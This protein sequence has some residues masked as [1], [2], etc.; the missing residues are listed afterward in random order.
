MRAWQ[1]LNTRNAVWQVAG[2][3]L[4]LG[5]VGVTG[6]Y[7][8]RGP[9][10]VKPSNGNGLFAG[11]G[12]QG[13]FGTVTEPL[14]QGLFVLS[15]ETILGRQKDLQLQGV[16]GRL[17]ET[18]T[19]WK[20]LSPQARKLD[21]TWTL[22]GPMAMEA[23]APGTSTLL[24]KGAIAAQGPALGWQHGVWSG[25]SPL[26]WEDLQGSGRGRWD[27]PSGWH[28][29]LDGRFIVEK[30]PVHWT[31]ADPGALRSLEAQRMDA[32][33][34]F[35]EGHLEQVRAQLV[36]GDLESAVVDILPQWINWGGPIGFH[37]Q[38]GWHGQASQG[39]APRPAQGKPFD[40]M[41]LKDFK[42]LRSVEGGQ[43]VL[44][45]EG[46]RWTPAGL[47]LEGG[48]RWEQPADGLLLTLRAPRVLQRTGPGEDL[49]A[50]LP[51]GEAWA[52]SQAVLT[53]G[54]RSLSSPR[55]EGRQK[56]RR[57]RILAPALGRSEFGT[58][59]AGEGRGTPARWEFDG[60]I[61]ARFTDGAQV[62]GDGLLWEGLV[63]TLTG[64]PATLTRIRQRLS[65]P[66]LVRREDAIQF[67]KGIAGALAAQDGDITLRADQGQANRAQVLLEGRVECQGQG[68]RLQADRI[69]VTLGP[70]N[71]VKQVKANGTVVLRGR[72]GEGR[73]DS[74]DLDP[75]SQ[76]ADWAGRVKAVTEV[77]P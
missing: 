49:P 52:E 45:A 53:W 57:W 72:M 3:G 66:Q 28:R 15:Y 31:A 55:I 43:E 74:L 48:V 26:V 12:T 77:R 62:R 47:R 73:G 42:A 33:L 34:G 9:R 27:L 7:V 20:L 46:A 13:R 39:R 17:E 37:R 56:Q 67:P 44:T 50:A 29:G 70:G 16:S 24:G 51:L 63:W 4:I 1:L 36:D 19:T 40:R 2:L 41:E 32:G 22:M 76:K 65:G 58:F 59:T 10:P 30:G 69:S 25:L 71:I 35:Q 5:V 61:L 75:V 60:P 21:D 54:A 18:A 64:R 68:W 8:A 23:V 6:V 14:G 11:P 38:D